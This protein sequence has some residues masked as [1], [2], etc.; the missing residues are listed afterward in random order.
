[1]YKTNC[2]CDS[3]QV[4]SACLKY[5]HVNVYSSHSLH[6]VSMA[7]CS[8]LIVPPLCCAA[9]G[10]AFATVWQVIV[11][12]EVICNQFAFKC[13]CCSCQLC[14]TLSYET[15]TQCNHCWN[16]F[17]FLHVG[18]CNKF[19]K[20][21]IHYL[22]TAHGNLH[23]IISCLLLLHIQSSEEINQNLLQVGM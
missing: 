13:P 14:Q 10:N 7:T 18:Q 8:G 5:L 1:M 17:F 9:S 22:P 16:K 3:R 6:H 12:S 20:F 23:L 11:A 19:N 21:K 4:V 2:H 15:A